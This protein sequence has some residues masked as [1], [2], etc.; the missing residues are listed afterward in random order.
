MSLHETSPAAVTG[1]KLGLALLVIAAAQLMIV[2]DGTIVTV[3]LPSIRAGLDMAESDLNWV[4]TSYALAFGGLL[5]VGGRAGDLFGRRRLFRLGLVV[6]LLASLLGGLAGNGVVLIAA[7][8]LQGLGAAVVAPTALSLLATT[9]PAGPARDKALGVYGAMGGLG[10]VVGLLLGGALT[11]Y[12]NWRWIMFVNVPFA[13]AVLLGTSVLVEGER[14]RGRVDLPG[15]I[16]A[17]LGLGSL[18]YAINR[19]S[20]A[21]WSDGLA[22]TFDAVAAVLLIGFVV[23]QRRSAAPM[24]PSSVLADRGRLGA[25][26]VMLLMGGGMLAT[27]YFLTLYMQAVKGYAPM[28][29]GLAYLPFA[30]GIGLGAGAV[31]P[32]LLGRTSARN[33]TMTGL[34]LAALGMGW[35]SFL[36]PG[37]NAFTVLLP[38]QL[39]AG[40]GLG[41]V[42]VAITIAGVRGVADQDAGIASGLIN[43]T[44]QIG[45][46]LGLAVLAAIATSTTRSQPPGTAVAAA[47]THGYTAGILAGGAL[48][49]A[50]ILAAALTLTRGR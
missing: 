35:F 5:L 13:I 36:T 10:A 31:G 4:L 24:M 7:R 32:P 46:A 45:G 2:L 40:I 37:Q 38:A 25:N 9:F 49:L 18:V 23:I 26:L 30:V 43:T 12:L 28:L 29:T 17:T 3:A 47:L 27:F 6:F 11:E 39:I 34:L 21:G 20:Q 1:R 41:L 42:T 44:Q 8:V 16:T 22:L 50:A 14:E 48:Y 19:A 33:V 15:A